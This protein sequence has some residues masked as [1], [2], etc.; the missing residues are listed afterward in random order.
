M[1]EFSYN[2]ER[3]AD[4]GL[5]SKFA[6]TGRVSSDEEDIGTRREIGS[7]SGSCTFT[8]EVNL[9]E[10]QCNFYITMDNTEGFFGYGTFLATGQMDN[11]GGRLHVTGA[12]YDF[13]TVSGG[14]V[15]LV[16]D[17]AGNP[18]FYVLIRLN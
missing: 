4:I 11:V 8:S 3:L 2:V 10:T 1:E 13:N 14:S 15:N 7:A 16:F 18:I 12:E 6:Y 5:G 17:P 9:M